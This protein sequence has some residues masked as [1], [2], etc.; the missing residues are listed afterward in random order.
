MLNLNVDGIIKA[1]EIR[2]DEF[3]GSKVNGTNIITEFMI[4]FTKTMNK[5]R[6]VRKI[7]PD[8]T[9]KIKYRLSNDF[10]YD[11]RKGISYVGTAELLNKIAEEPDF[12]DE[13]G[14]SNAFG[15]KS[16]KILHAIMV[17][18]S[19]IDVDLEFII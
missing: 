14:I 1:A 4:D 13:S 2:K 19:W 10:V 5:D 8:V 11:P 15:F 6:I 18:S 17:N 3:M 9:H 16:I 7:E 12:L